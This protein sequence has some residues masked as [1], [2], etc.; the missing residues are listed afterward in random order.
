[1]VTRHPRLVKTFRTT[2]CKPNPE[3][4]GLKILRLLLLSEN[5]GGCFTD[6]GWILVLVPESCFVFQPDS[7]KGFSACQNLYVSKIF[8]LSSC[9]VHGYYID[10]EVVCNLDTTI[11][12]KMFRRVLKFSTRL[13]GKKLLGCI[14]KLCG[15]NFIFLSVCLLTPHMVSDFKKFMFELVLHL[16]FAC[17]NRYS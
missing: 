7:I 15:S 13:S 11:P 10:H 6:S 14:E 2:N 16:S 8:R 4:T 1:M 12:Q 5:N 17:R 3:R 9:M